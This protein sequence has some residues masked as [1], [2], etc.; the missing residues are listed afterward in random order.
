M[1]GPNIGAFDGCTRRILCAIKGKGKK[2][3]EEEEA[4]GAASRPAQLAARRPAWLVA[5]LE[6]PN[7]WREEA[8]P[9][10]WVPAGGRS[11][12][13]AGAHTGWDG[14]VGVQRPDAACGGMARRVGA[15]PRLGLTARGGTS[16]PAS[17]I[18]SGPN[19]ICLAL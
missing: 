5:R 13:G 3:K 10:G 12:Q 9:P 2:A 14:L 17:R 16:S 19:K 11:Q 4:N 6:W 1:F 8:G 15:W 18:S 7:R